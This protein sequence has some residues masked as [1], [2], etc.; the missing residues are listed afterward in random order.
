MSLDLE[1]W[2]RKNQGHELEEW[3]DKR[4]ELLTASRVNAS[5]SPVPPTPNSRLTH[6]RRPDLVND[7]RDSNGIPARKH[8]PGSAIANPC[9]LSRIGDTL[10]DRRGYKT[11]R[12]ARAAHV[13]TPFPE[14]MVAR[15]ARPAAAAALALAMTAAAVMVAAAADAEQP[16]PREAVLEAV[17]GALLDPAAPLPWRRAPRP[18]WSLPNNLR[19]MQHITAMWEGVNN[20]KMWALQ[21]ADASTKIPEGLMFGN[22]VHLGN[23]DECL[24]VKSGTNGP[25]GFDGQHCLVTLKIKIAWCAPSSCEPKD[26]EML[27]NATLPDLSAYGLQ[28]S[29]SVLPSQ[30]HVDEPVILRGIDIFA[31]CLLGFFVV[32]AVL[33]TIYDIFTEKKDNRPSLL[34]AFSM[35]SNWPKILTVNTGQDQLT[36]LNGIR[37]IS[38]GWV[39]LGHVYLVNAALPAINT[40]DYL[41]EFIR[42]LERLTIMNATVSVDTFFMMSGLFRH[43][44]IKE[45]CS[46]NWWTNLLYVN[47]YVNPDRM[48]LGHTW[49]LAVD[50][51]LHWLSPLV[52]VPLWKMR[53]RLA[54]GWVIYL[55]ALG[56]AIPFTIVYIME[57]YPGIYVGPAEKRSET[58]KYYYWPT[59]TRFVPWLLGVLLGY[60]LRECR[61]EKPVIHPVLI[62]CGW[63]TSTVLMT[64]ALNAAYPF[65]QPG[66]KYN[67]VEA[68]FW[69]SLFRP[70]WAVGL[71]WIIFACDQGYGGLVDK[72]LSWNFFQPLA[73]LSYGVYLTHITILNL[74]AG[75]IQSP[76]YLA[77][78]N[79]IPQFFG[80]LIMSVA[81]AIPLALL[82]ES[83]IILLEKAILGGGRRPA[84]AADKEQG[85]KEKGEKE[86]P[87]SNGGPKV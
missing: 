78:V 87:I 35:Y 65:Q 64:G 58:M 45:E 34:L 83:P 69:L 50:M 22:L 11:A 16:T 40:L 53:K 48:C 23:F 71:G 1:P 2:R 30:C 49:Y 60:I 12:A 51:Q 21:M 38:I 77:D 14:A 31:I 28:V 47:N 80:V 61:K 62:T 7:H 74:F 9:Y 42:A 5:P 81:W 24:A 39:V 68:A 73:R 84:P 57:L 63:I 67:R 54:M 29:A 17:A 76:V 32:C 26:L 6:V 43:N 82:F 55:I 33:S 10:G 44:K 4:T 13:D 72:I 37:T 56:W 75:V 27:A 20:K 86:V 8:L 36:C 46:D 19:C 66:W 79:A 70:L 3:Y 18:E 25:T 15:G 59:H 52:L 41:P 85:I